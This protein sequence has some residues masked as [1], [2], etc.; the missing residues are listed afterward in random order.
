VETRRLAEEAGVS[1]D[2]V[3]RLLTRGIIPRPARK[4]GVSYLWSDD[5][6]ASAKQIISARRC[7]KENPK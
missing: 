5:E 2:C 3:F 7:R 6:V 1:Y 4:V